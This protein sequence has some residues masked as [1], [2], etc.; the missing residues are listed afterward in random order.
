MKHIELQKA[1]NISNNAAVKLNKD[2]PV[3]MSVLL[4]ICAALNCDFAGMMEAIPD[5]SDVEPE[6]EENI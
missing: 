5:K 1:A 4:R 2:E 6:L 3:S